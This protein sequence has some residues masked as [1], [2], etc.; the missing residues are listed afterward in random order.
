MNYLFIQQVNISVEESPTKRK[1]DMTI[2]ENYAFTGV[3]HIFDQVF[4]VFKLQVDWSNQDYR[5]IF[6]YLKI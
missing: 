4:I 5:V 2:S 3:H 6:I 1:N